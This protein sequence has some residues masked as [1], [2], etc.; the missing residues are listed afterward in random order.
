M[1]AG[2]LSPTPSTRGRQIPHAPTVSVILPTFNRLKYLRLTVESVFAQTF[3]DWELVIVDDGSEAETAAYLALLANDPRVRARRV[4]H[5]GNPSLIRNVALRMSQ[6]EYVAFLDSDDLWMPR[7]LE[8]QVSALRRT[9]GSRWSYTGMIGIGKNG[10]IMPGEFSGCR[11]LHEGAI[12]E[13]LLTMEADIATP[14]VMAERS[15]I[16]E[17]GGFDE[18]QLFFEDYDLWLRLN[19]V[20]EVS[21]IHEPLVLVRNHDDGENYSADRVSNYRARFRLLDKISRLSSASHLRST[22]QLERAK[23]AA[24]LSMALAASGSR[25]EALKMLWR[26]RRYA[27]YSRTWWLKARVTVVRALTPAW[28]RTIRRNQP[29]ARSTQ[30]VRLG[31]HRSPE[32][33]PAD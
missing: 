26:S 10:G 8:V 24:D 5:S 17:V 14:S 15:L 28:V 27:W 13:K 2:Q 9:T 32:T 20:S 33:H 19:L 3:S 30:T 7:K 11:V 1:K 4:P 31:K 21:A 18:H 16:E 6:G 12:L 25:I 23:T 29:R 22:L